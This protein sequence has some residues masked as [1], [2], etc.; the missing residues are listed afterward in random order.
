MS[1]IFTKTALIRAQMSDVLSAVWSSTE[2]KT[3]HGTSRRDW[4]LVTGRGGGGLQHERGGGK[5]SF[6]PTKRRSEKVLALLKGGG[7]GRRNRF[8]G[9]FTTGT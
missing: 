7:G 6:T 4:S 5:W 1:T 3:T 8:S 9:S 2:R